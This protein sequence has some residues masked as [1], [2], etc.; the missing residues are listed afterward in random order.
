MV[1]YKLG[2]FLC[3]R[4]SCS[5]VSC[6]LE[7]PF[8]A[9]VTFALFFLL[10]IVRTTEE[11]HMTF[12]IFDFTFFMQLLFKLSRPIEVAARGHAFVVGFSKTLALH[13]VCNYGLL[14]SSSNCHCEVLF[15]LTLTML[16]LSSSEFS[17]ILLP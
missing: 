9:R 2:H 13:E 11:N 7:V 10:V 1:Q 3:Q 8:H 15:C 5:D 12:I 17:S 6:Y 14:F 4:V 16:S